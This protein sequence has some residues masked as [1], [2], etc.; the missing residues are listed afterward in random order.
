M[1]PT[2]YLPFA[3]EAAIRSRPSPCALGRARR[4]ARAHSVAAAIERE[5]P[6]AV[7][8]VPHARRSDRGVAD[9]GAAGRDAGGFFGV[10]GLLLA[11]SASMA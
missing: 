9:P 8:S 6:T 10:L 7:L 5:D 4:R 3:Q 2:M 1:E 11:R